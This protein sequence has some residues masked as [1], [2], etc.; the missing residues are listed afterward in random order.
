M[1]NWKEQFDEREIKEIE[2]ARTYAGQFAHG[3]P[4]HLHLTVIAKLADLLDGNSP[5]KKREVIA[6]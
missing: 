4:G 1:G 5:N 2:F 3:T 6:E